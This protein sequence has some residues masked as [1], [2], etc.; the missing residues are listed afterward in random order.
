MTKKRNYF[1][2]LSYSTPMKKTNKKSSLNKLSPVAKNTLD[3]LNA[4]SRTIAKRFKRSDLKVLEDPRAEVKTYKFTSNA[5]YNHSKHSSLQYIDKLFSPEVS[6]KITKYACLRKPTASGELSDPAG[7]E[8]AKLQSYGISSINVLP[9]RQAWYQFNIM[10]LRDGTTTMH[11]THPT[12]PSKNVPQ[13]FF[14]TQIDM[15]DLWKKSINM[16]SST[17][18]NAPGSTDGNYASGSNTDDFVEGTYSVNSQKHFYYRGGSYTLFLHNI[19]NN[20]LIFKFYEYI[21][22]EVINGEDEGKPLFYAIK[23]KLLTAPRYAGSGT[24]TNETF[25][26][27]L[28]YQNVINSNQPDTTDVLGRDADDTDDLDFKPGYGTLLSTNF[29]AS[30]CKVFTLRP[31]DRLE[32]QVEIPAWSCLD[33]SVMSSIIA[34]G[35]ANEMVPAFSKI[36]CMSVKGGKSSSMYTIDHDNNDATAEV[37]NHTGEVLA[38]SGSFTIYQEEKHTAFAKPFYK[39]HTNIIINDLNEHWDKLQ[40]EHIHEGT[41]HEFVTRENVVQNAPV[42]VDMDMN[43]NDNP[44]GNTLDAND[45]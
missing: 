11:A 7:D 20:D 44:T 8:A 25:D 17:L 29:I 10:G 16:L 22:R 14:S 23:D 34:K 38:G 2:T 45:Y 39:N 13:K 30:K 19:S 4:T 37:Y 27:V 31:G 26:P 6:V 24:N 35:K 1:S 32:Y 36:L 43:D 21:P 18:K 41:F 5:P 9:E 33:G 42:N 3:S 12:L 28:N 40:A 15:A